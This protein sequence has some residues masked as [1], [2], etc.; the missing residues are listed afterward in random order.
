MINTF[1]KDLKRGKQ[2]EHKVLNQIKTKY[3]NAYIEKGYF[4]EWDIFI[5][6]LNFGVEV[7]YDEKSKYTGNIVIEINFNN[8]PS[9]LSTTKAKYWVIY[10]GYK[11]NWFL[12]NDINKCINDN[13]LKYYS[14]I[15]KGDIKM[16]DAYLIKKEILYK[17]MTV[18]D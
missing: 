12:V 16:K 11:Y 3:K 8:K 5:P 13:N 18:N 4:K 2:I 7:K 9:A 14:F 10:D 1:N 17:Y 6:E 15:G